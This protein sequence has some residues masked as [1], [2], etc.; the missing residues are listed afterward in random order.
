M[1]GGYEETGRPKTMEMDEYITEFMRLESVVKMCRENK[2]GYEDGILAYRLLM[3][4]NLTHQQVQL[5]RAT[6]ADLSLDLMKDALK[7]AFGEGNNDITIIVELHRDQLA[8]QQ[9]R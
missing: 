1:L 4:A 7:R 6:T 2:A 9:H 3:Q 8:R 5:V